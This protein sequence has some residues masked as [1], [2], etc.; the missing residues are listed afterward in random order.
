MYLDKIVAEKQSDPAF[1]R[2]KEVDWEAEL[3]RA[4][5]P[6]QRGFSKSLRDSQGP[7]IIAEMKRASPSKGSF[8]FAG[9]V[10]DQVAS[11]EKGGARAV[12]VLTN[13]PFFQGSL[14]DLAAARQGTAL[15][16]LHL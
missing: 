2:G 15:P 9:R 6:E 11:Y 7:S 5:V 1:R 14:T 3:A 4:E 12:S 8:E 16:P 10:E 13:G